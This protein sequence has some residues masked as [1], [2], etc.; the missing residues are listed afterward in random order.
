MTLSRLDAMHEYWRL[1]PPVHRLVA[2]YMQY[3]PPDRKPIESVNIE[4]LIRA[5][6]G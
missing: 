2:M 4:E 1:N 6:G 3:K 5:L